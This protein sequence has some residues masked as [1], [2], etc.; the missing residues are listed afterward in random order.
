MRLFRLIVLQGVALA[1]VVPVVTAAEQG[2]MF[3]DR[4]HQLLKTYCWKCHGGEARQAGLDTRSL[5]LLLKG[6]KH[7]AAIVPG[8]AKQSLLYQKLVS[9]KM[10]PGKELRPT[11][12]HIRLIREWI[13]GGAQARYQKRPLNE[14][15]DPVLADNAR[16]WWSFQPPVR[17]PVPEVREIARTRTAVDSFVISRLESSGLSLA[18]PADRRALAR[19]IHLDLIGLPPSPRELQVFLA[20]TSPGAWSRLVDRLLGSPHFGERWGRHWL[21]AAG[22]VDTIGSDNDAGTIKPAT[23]IWRYRDYCI[24]SINADKRFDEFLTEQLAGDEL[25]K[26]REAKDYTPGMLQKLIATGFLRQ[27]RDVTYAPEL[28]T[29][30]IRHQVLFDTLQTVSSSLLG[31]TIHCA[32]CHTHKFDPIRQADYYRLAAV[33]TPSYDVQNWVNSENRHLFTVSQKRKLHIDAHNGRIN[34]QTDDLKKKL[35]AV[36]ARASARVAARKLTALPESIR[37]DTGTAVKVAQEKRTKVQAY[38]AEKLGP[39]LKVTAPEIDKELTVEERQQTAAHQARIDLLNGTRESYEKIQALWERGPAPPTYLYRRGDFTTPGPQVVPGVPAVLDPA[40][41]L[42]R[43]Q[44]PPEGAET[45]GYR[46]AF[47]KWL[48]ASDHPL[49]ARVIVNRMWQKYFGRG[50]VTT[51]DNFGFSGTQPTHPRLLD[52]LARELVESGWSMKHVHRLVLLSAVYR[53]STSRSTEEW[54][55]AVAVDPD[56]QLLWRMPLRRLE[57]EIIRDSV[58]SVSGTLDRY[59]GGPAVPIK[60]NADSSVVIDVGKIARP[61]DPFRRSLYLLCRRNYQLTELG[62]FDQPT[63]AHN[64]T[65]RDSSAVVLQSLA[66]LNGPFVMQQSR[67]FG[68]RVRQEAGDDRTRR[69]KLSFLLALGRPATPAELPVVETFLERHTASTSAEIAI[70]HLC[71][72]LLNTNEFL[73]VP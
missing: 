50:I 14:A 26:W 2:P 52:Y 41:R 18:A 44:A 11:D 35:D 23:G 24:A 45:S 37:S 69:I 56:N 64:C 63:V 31:L 20:D 12:A 70:D 29:A 43:I 68:A 61:G 42:T 38:L 28:N 34:Q 32:Q 33:F 19:R 36:R 15:E 17:P 5:P 65:R 4:V 27:A 10:P 8:N 6:G 62:V 54:D 1:I 21:D 57:S 39:L 73:Y 46:L 30:D 59:Q 48:T 66:M 16:D 51:T 53:Q 72:M 55:R 13:D 3:E 22:Y 47:S 9:G 49:T 40:A 71:H 25:V 7:G 60:S 58:L 67:R